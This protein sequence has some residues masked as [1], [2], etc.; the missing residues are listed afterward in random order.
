MKAVIGRLISMVVTVLFISFVV[1][2]AFSLIPGD[3]A[4]TI[5]GGQADPAKV[6][7]LREQMGLNDP[8]LIRYGRWLAGFLHGDMGSSYQYDMP[9]A[10]L[11]ADKIPITLTLTL[12]AF[13]LMILFSIPLG[14][15]TAKHE[16]GPADRFIV[17]FNQIIMAIP[18]FFSGILITW[19]FGMLL[20]WFTPGG[21]VSWE[22]DF[23]AFLGYL[24]FPALAIALPKTAM[25]V[26]LLR[27][28]VLVEAGRDYTRTAYSRG[29]TTNGVLYYH[30][31]K[32][33][34]LPVLTF[35]GMTLADMVAGSIII[36][37]V[38]GIPGLGRTLLS[39]I[40]NRDY[41]VIEAIII[42]IAVIVVLS[43]LIVDILYQVLDPQ[44]R[45]E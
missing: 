22:A 43:G 36:E 10:D 11:L 38:F 8:V 13:L 9:V 26:K 34:V 45:M 23:G 5:L 3:P 25:A 39:S 28:S 15:Y 33:A 20:H 24:F 18:P 27:S 30:V 40:G 32:N 29:N 2:M 35:L 4:L 14:L 37:Q 31:L 19:I 44:I 17:V 41:P 1:F 42:L 12:E 21:Y 6:E 16:G 7:A